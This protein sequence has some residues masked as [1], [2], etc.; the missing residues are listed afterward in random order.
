MVKALRMS[1]AELAAHQK[2]LN[3]RV[4]KLVMEHANLPKIA[5]K[6]ASKPARIDAEAPKPSKYGAVKTDGYH[7]KKEAKI[8]ADLKLRQAAGEIRNLR[9]QVPFVIIPKQ[10]GERACKYI[11]DFVFEEDQPLNGIMPSNWVLVV[12]DAKGYRTPTYKIKRKLMRL[13]HGIVV[14]EV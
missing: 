8:A 14:V 5:P 10:D 11:A 1:E 9:E 6:N 2:R 7:S 3:S 4:K 13:V 12:L